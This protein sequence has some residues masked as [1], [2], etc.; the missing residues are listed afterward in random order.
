MFKRTK[1]NRYKPDPEKARRRS[2][3]I[4]T[5]LQAR[6]QIMT[7]VVILIVFS[8]LA[9]YVHDLLVQS[10]FFTIQTIEIT[11]NQRV[12][13]EDALALADLERPRNIF[14]VNTRK[15]E[16]KLTA[17]PWVA[18]A[19]VN[20]AD[21]STLEITLTEEDALAIVNVRNIARILINAQ[22]TP[23]KE[24]EPEKDKAESLPEISGVDLT[25]VDMGEYQFEAPLFDPI[26]ELLREPVIPPIVH[27]RTDD[28]QGLIIET[29]DT[30][31]PTPSDPQALMSI[32]L[33]KENFR[34]KLAR[35]RQIAV[36]METHF[37]HKNILAMDLFNLETIFIK[38]S[39]NEGLQQ[40]A[41]KGA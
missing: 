29:R 20:R 33:G 32:K 14:Q 8:V 2:Q 19:Q 4:Q 26:L 28:I 25:E 12:S 22:G 1:A 7:P 21:L 35:A 31:N 34:E 38:T 37:P 17:H 13:R 18:Q 5:I 39:D 30:F 41:N 27:A 23:F 6:G 15:M 40:T 9:V 3:R 16:M 10:P 36:Y 24:Y 11:G